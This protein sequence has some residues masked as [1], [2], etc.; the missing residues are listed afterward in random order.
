MRY[1]LNTF[2]VF[3]FCSV[4]AQSSDTV[5]NKIDETWTLKTAKKYWKFSPFDVI[6]ILPTFGTDVEIRLNETRSFQVGIGLIPK[7]SKGFLSQFAGFDGMFGYRLRGESR[8]KIPDKGNCYLAVGLSLRHLIIKDEIYVGMGAFTNDWGSINYVYFQRVDASA[9]RF[10]INLDLKYG[11][12]NIKTA[13]YVL[14]FYA[15][16]SIRSLVI[17]GESGIPEGGHTFNAER[18][19]WTIAENY[20]L[21]YPTPIAGVKIGFMN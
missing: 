12:Q 17:R 11:F 2:L 1:L 5:S 8:F 4:N 18:G 6:S 13:G 7:F 16:L 10:N 3:Y 9:N 20:N 14:D 19:I 15:G 21:F